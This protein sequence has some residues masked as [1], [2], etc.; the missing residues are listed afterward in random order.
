MNTIK[1]RQGKYTTV[2]NSFL[3]D[4]NISFKAKGLFCYMFS[5]SDG[6]NFTLQSIATQ[7]NDGLSSIKSAMDELKEFGYVVYEKHANGKGTYHLN[8]DPKVEN[9]NV[10][11]PNVDFTIEGKSTPIKNNN[12]TKKNNSKNTNDKKKINKKEIACS[13]NLDLAK[14]TI[15]YLNNKTNKRFR[16][17]PG[18]LKEIKSQITKLTKQGDTLEQIEE[19]FAYVINAKVAEWLHNEKMK[20]NLNP[21]TL[22][23]EANFDRYLNQDIQYSAAD[24][25][26]KI[27][28]ARE[29]GIM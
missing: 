28:E 19:K 7:Q 25:I 18:N 4:N 23:R 13:E 27:Y 11:N 15:D 16:H 22:F 1:K 14:R 6:W 26:D 2:S 3:R 24:M 20:K 17:N 5:M 9:P 12:S 8:D 21:I 29:R 10:E